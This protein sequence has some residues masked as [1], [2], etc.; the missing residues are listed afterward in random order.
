MEDP[1][2]TSADI[3]AGETAFPGRS[4]SGSGS[5]IDDSDNYAG[6]SSGSDD[7]S[8]TDTYRGSNSAETRYRLAYLVCVLI[9]FGCTVTNVIAYS[10]N[11]HSVFAWKDPCTFGGNQSVGAISVPTAS[12]GTCGSTQRPPS[13]G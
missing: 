13:C 2:V 3:D 9:I 4:R 6:A 5:T 10:K 7:K 1:L 11:I 12:C 8:D